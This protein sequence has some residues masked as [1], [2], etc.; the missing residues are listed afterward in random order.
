MHRLGGR[1]VIKS[2][3]R[4]AFAWPVGASRDWSDSAPHCSEKVF[5]KPDVFHGSGAARYSEA[6]EPDEADE[7]EMVYDRQFGP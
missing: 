7:P 1:Y 5:R 4:G 3:S 2:T 6:D